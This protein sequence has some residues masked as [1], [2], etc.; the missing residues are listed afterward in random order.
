M[1]KT[2]DYHVIE[3]D[4][5]A[6]SAV[7]GL[8]LL[9]PESKQPHF[10]KRLYLITIIQLSYIYL[11]NCVDEPNFLFVFNSGS[12]DRIV[13]DDSAIKKLLDRTQA[14]HVEKVM[15]MNEYLSSFKVANY[16]IKEGEEEVR[17]G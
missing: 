4:I 14:G 15:A 13:Y 5:K 2:V 10:L 7:N 11:L 8:R 3:L 16:T 1:E 12:E 6:E 9:K 17:A